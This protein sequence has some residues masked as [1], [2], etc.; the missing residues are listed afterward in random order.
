MLQSQVNFGVTERVRIAVSERMSEILAVTNAILLVTIRRAIFATE[1]F[2]IV[3]ATRIAI[4]TSLVVESIAV[5]VETTVVVPMVILEVAVVVST[6]LEVDR[7]FVA[8]AITE[9][10]PNGAVRMSVVV[11]RVNS[12]K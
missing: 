2:V 4:A 8:T 9:F 6:S 11:T 7:R 12:I 10:V 3:V 1:V 5:V